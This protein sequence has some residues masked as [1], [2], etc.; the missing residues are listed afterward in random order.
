MPGVKGGFF[1]IG[2]SGAIGKGKKSKMGKVAVAPAPPPPPEYTEGARV[3]HDVIQL[4]PTGTTTY[5]A[6]N[7]EQYDTDAIHDPVVSNSRL[8]CKTA[9]KYVISTSVGWETNAKEQRRLD[10]RLNR[11]SNIAYVRQQACLQGTT[12]QSVTT[13]YDLAVGDYIEV[14]VYQNSGGNLDLNV[15]YDQSPK[16]S[17]QRIG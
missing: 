16:L 8:T 6:F 2:P 5:V 1:S 11:T 9:G 15:V 14:S 4:I 7:S 12:N 3:Y 10:I 17:M 13:I